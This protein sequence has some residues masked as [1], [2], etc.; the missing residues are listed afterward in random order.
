MMWKAIQWVCLQVSTLSRLSPVYR[1]SIWILKLLGL[2]LGSSTIL[3]VHTF[4]PASSVAILSLTPLVPSHPVFFCS[5]LSSLCPW[6]CL[7]KHCKDQITRE[8]I[9]FFMRMLTLEWEFMRGN[10]RADEPRASTASHWNDIYHVVN[11]ISWQYRCSLQPIWLIKFK[12]YGSSALFQIN[13][14]L[15]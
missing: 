10:E 6:I 5:V 14:K 8:V 4:T 3:L 15:V 7:L 13:P 12:V 9:I 11:V 1:H 2:N